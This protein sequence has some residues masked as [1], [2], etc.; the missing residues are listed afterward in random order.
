MLACRRALTCPRVCA[1]SCDGTGELQALYHRDL[2]R[3]RSALTTRGITP[4][5]SATPQAI[6]ALLQQHVPSRELEGLEAQIQA[7]IASRTSPRANALD[8]LP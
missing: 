8:E 5:V 4:P 1:R 2:E 3:R 6:D 7:T